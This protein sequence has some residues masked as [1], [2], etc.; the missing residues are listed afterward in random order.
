[1]RNLKNSKILRVVNLKKWFEVRRGILSSLL[2]QKKTFVHAVDGVSFDVNKGEIFCL[3]GE[4]GCGKTTTGKLI[5]RL[6]EPT[7]GK[8]YFENI[9]IFTMKKEDF[10]KIRPKIQM[11]FQDPYE[12]LNPRM[13][14]FDLVMEP[15]EVNK[16]VGDYEE[17]V[18]LVFKTL[19]AVELVPPERY[20]NLLPY[21]LS[22]G[23]RQRVM[24]ARALILSP[25]F[26]VADEPVS[27][28]DVSIRAG[29]LNLLLNLKEKYDISYLFITHDLS[30][31]RYVS[32]RIGIMYLGKIVEMG[33]TEDVISEPLHPYTKA[34]VSIAP[35]PK[36]LAIKEEVILKGEP[37]NPIDLPRG[38]RFHP[39][40]PYAIELCKRKEPPL[41][42][43]EKGHYV[44]CHV[45]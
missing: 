23:E 7:D 29:I 19:E 41:R 18:E 40:C 35:T 16:I 8:V 22:G 17:K 32:D 27:M 34:L 6:V 9:D 24:I 36:P 20:V 30:V 15:L 26:L 14:V 2:S 37:P 33:V 38:C 45:V 39:R 21:K 3:A 1:M 43:I 10:K 42:E 28:L 13:N 11:I 25:K 31:A 12:S 4:S 44:A 5:V